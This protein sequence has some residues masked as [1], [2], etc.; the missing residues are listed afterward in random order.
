LPHL[1]ALALTRYLASNGCNKYLFENVSALVETQHELCMAFR[2]KLAEPFEEGVRR[3]AREQIERAQSQL[4]GSG[5]PVVAVHE[6][7]KSMKRLRALL[8]LVRPALGESAFREENARLR[9]IGADLSS[10]RDRHVLLETVVKLEANSSLARKGL[11]QVMRDVLHV[12]NG[13][14]DPAAEAAAIKQA[15]S[16]LVE[17]KKRFA[18]LRL[19]GK[20]FEVVGA[21]LE[22]CY[23]KARRSFHGAYAEPSD[24]GFHEWRKGTQQHWRHMVLFSRAWS[25]CFNARIA[26]ARALSQLLGDDHDLALL[27]GFVQAEKGSALDAAQVTAIE[28]LARQ[29]QEELRAVAHP[30]G[31]RLFSEGA[32]SLRRRM[33]AYWDAAVVLKELAPDEDDPKAKDAHKDQAEKAPQRG[34]GRRRAAAAQAS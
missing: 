19:E 8:R 24:E 12:S 3:I 1:S 31:V 28:K 7:R 32:R 14:E 30:R 9:D 6:T 27:V 2:F 4:K 18:Q 20:G 13:R 22:A 16:R 26:E 34:S 25:G 17:A 10:T 29:R 5:D 11:G 15:L 33:A 21:G 23:R